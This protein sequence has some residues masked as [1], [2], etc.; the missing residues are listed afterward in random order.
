MDDIFDIIIVGGGPCGLSASVYAGRSGLKTLLLEEYA[1][2]G[3]ML[4]TTEIKNYPGFCDVSGIELGQK[5]E[6]RARDLGVEIKFE[7]VLDFDFSSKVKIV[8]T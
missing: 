6:K 8:K 3:Q 7:K 2:G 5:I 4:N 1:C